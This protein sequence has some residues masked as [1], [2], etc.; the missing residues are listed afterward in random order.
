MTN[1]LILSIFSFL[2]VV[3]SLVGQEDHPLYNINDRIL[4]AQDE[5][6]RDGV[7]KIEALLTPINAY[8]ETGNG[9]WK[10]YWTAYTKFQQ[11]NF[12]A[13]NS[14]HKDEDIAK[15]LTGEAIKILS[16]IKDKNA[17]DY[18]LLGYIKGY[19]LQ[20]I[21][22]LKMPKESGKAGKWVAKAVEMAPDNPRSNMVFGNNDF[23]TP[24][25]FGGGKAV[26]SSMQKAISLYKEAVPNPYMPS[27]GMPKAYQMLT[28]HYLKNDMIAQAKATITEGLQRYP[29]HK[30]LQSLEDKVLEQ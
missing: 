18:A 25:M 4:S 13:Y 15:E 22:F 11:S 24:K 1:H 30:T 16:D 27:W 5:S 21:S 6:F 3:S 26:E 14:Y 10:A 29:E 23:Y 9:H 17:E 8:E 7:D 28:R 12:W 2:I 20:W 19:S